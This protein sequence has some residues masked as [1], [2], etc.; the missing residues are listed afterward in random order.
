MFLKT[1]VERYFIKTFCV[2]FIYVGVK[3]T[4][5]SSYSEIKKKNLNGKQHLHCLCEKVRRGK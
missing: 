5:R 2:H 4:Y 3:Q 1:T